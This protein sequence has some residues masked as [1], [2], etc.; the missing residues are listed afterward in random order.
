[1]DLQDTLERLTALPVP[2]RIRLAQALWDSIP[3]GDQA[4]EPTD[5]QKRLID[6]RTA[7]LDA[8]PGDVLTWDQIKTRVR[9]R[10]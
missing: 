8:N 4:A 9:G 3:G 2:D 1:M 5:D 7:E 6:R 10:P